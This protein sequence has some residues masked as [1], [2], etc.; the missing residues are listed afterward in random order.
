M[1]VGRSRRRLTVGLLGVV[2]ASLALGGTAAS[3]DEPGVVEIRKANELRP[4]TVQ[5]S[6]GT[7]L[8]WVNKDGSAHRVR[9]EGATFDSGTL[10]KDQRFSHR[11]DQAGTYAYSLGTVSDA[12]GSSTST[13]SWWSGGVVEVSGGTPAPTAAPTSPPATPPHS[14]A[15]V[16]IQDNSFS[17]ATLSVAVGTTV[18]W[19]HMGSAKHTV[20][21]ASF[22]SGILSAGATF[23]YT[24]L[25]PGTY[26]YRCDLHSGMTGTIVVTGTGTGTTPSPTPVPTPA[27]T[28]APTVPA[29]A[30]PTGASVSISDNS[31][32]PPSLTVPVG[33]TVVWT[34]RG[35]SKHTVT[36]AGTFDSGILSP[37]TTFSFTFTTAGTYGYVCELHGGMSGTIVVTGT[38]TGT[39]PAP[40]P[41]PTLA[42]TP[43][44][45]A[46]PAGTVSVTIGDDYFSP[47]TVSV[48]PGTT[49][50][51]TNRGSR[52]HT[53]TGVGA[54]S[55]M[56]RPGES[57]SMRFDTA[58]GFSYACEFH[59]Q[60]SGTVL[61]AAAGA[62]APT[63][64]PTPIP[65][66][67]PRPAVPPGAVVVDVDDNTFTPATLNIATGTKVTFANIGRAPHTV[68]ASDGSFNAVL[69]KGSTF[70]H[71]FHRPGTYRY[72]CSFH[73]GMRGVIVVTGE[74]V[75]GAGPTPS[76]TPTPTATPAG[77]PPPGS[78][79][80]TLTDNR[81]EP[82]SLTVAAGTTVVWVNGGR[83]PHTVTSS[84][85]PFDSGILAPGAT[86]SITFERA[87]H[88]EY[89]C[90]LHE[91]MI[92]AIDVTGA[93]ANGAPTI[94]RVGAPL[95]SP[96]P[97]S[98][99]PST[100]AGA[101][102]APR[103]AIAVED[104]LFTPKNA[105]IAAGTVVT[106]TNVG[107][108]KHTVTFTADGTTSPLF[109]TGE[110]WSRTFTQPGTYAYICALHPGMTGTLVVTAASAE[111]TTTTA[112]SASLIPTDAPMTH[113]APLPVGSTSA[114]GW[115]GGMLLGIALT[116]MAVLGIGAPVAMALRGSP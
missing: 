80:L 97:A 30:P 47:A 99:T 41:A 81:F 5:V 24:F 110:S 68:T 38:G 42:P 65:T 73:T 9:A 96:S 31:F 89:L 35:G 87:G 71:V 25:S 57:Y 6:A 13:W 29:P 111:A 77:P 61:V 101:T 102:T 105:E 106:W 44:P 63:V 21:S 27:P 94:T 86:F 4:A 58:G 114:L 50:T 67:P 52:S 28:A 100:A 2:L 46:A 83:V 103:L 51:W 72:V 109:G 108:V 32:S 59:P 64:A 85:T 33:T 34:N 70:E 7:T 90:E 56:L 14:G 48:I 26:A 112:P 18:T 76:P 3:S 84:A 66:A 16:H 19:M 60:M 62:P 115:Q 92:G 17:P 55:G 74:A 22:D 95:R 37:G 54:G 49:V 53:V 45:T 15:M 82:P 1:A 107:K 93:T 78:R 88:Y 43:A 36:A 79:T 8:T 104:N 12:S 11:F 69:S 39:T 75:A 116:L 10:A 113:M 91:G 20:T 98:P 40:T 23:S